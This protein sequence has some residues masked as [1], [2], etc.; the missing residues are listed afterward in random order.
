M[1][2]ER[3]KPQVGYNA[4][5]GLAV[6]KILKIFSSMLHIMLTNVQC[7]F[8]FVLQLNV[9]VNNFFFYFD[10]KVTG[11][12]DANS[13]H[14]TVKCAA[15]TQCIQMYIITTSEQFSTSSHN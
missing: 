14:R 11:F 3:F 4:M 8:C 6:I 9:A 15:D 12:E 1:L 5:A 7:K 10:E 2:T 13:S